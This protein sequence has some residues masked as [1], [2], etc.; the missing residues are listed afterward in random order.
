MSHFYYWEYQRNTKFA[1]CFL[2]GHGFLHRDFTDQR[3]IWHDAS[4][5]S[6]T[7]FLKFWG[8]ISG[9]AKL[10]PFFF[11]RRRLERYVLLTHFFYIYSQETSDVSLV[12]LPP[13][14]YGETVTLTFT[15][16]ISVDEISIFTCLKPRTST[17]NALEYSE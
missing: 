13:R 10:W 8:D 3:E 15:E 9:T 17:C 6:E 7:G 4:P 12:R 16:D 14:T 11:L 5:M 2:F 1:V